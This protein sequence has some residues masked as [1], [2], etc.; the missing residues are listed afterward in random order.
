MRTLTLGLLALV[1]TARVA[2]AQFVTGGT[3]TNPYSGTVWNNPMSSLVATMIQ[4]RINNRMLDISIARSRQARLG[5]RPPAGTPP[6][7]HHEPFSKTAFRPHRSRLVVKAIIAGLAQNEEQ[8][9]GLAAGI[10][11]VFA[12]FEKAP[13]KDNVAYALAFMIAASLGV[14]TGTAVTDEQSEA[15]AVAIND[16]L[17]RSRGFASASALDRQK[18]YEGCVTLGGLVMLFAEVGK[19][20]PAS[21]KAAKAIAR[22]ALAM[23]GI[24]TASGQ[25]QAAA[26]SSSP[27]A[28][29]ASCME[30]LS[31]YGRCQPLTGDCMSSCEQHTTPASAQ[32]ARAVLQCMG[33]S[34]CG[35]MGCV[36]QHCGP[37]VTA[38]TGQTLPG[39]RR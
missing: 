18:L 4:N 25:S 12:E 14:Q 3:W 2:A 36:A 37:Q 10:D 31:C 13:R 19:R 21:A 9:K 17:A 6:D 5:A 11:I 7:E 28:A 32:Q 16:A 29:T 39:A 27:S 22:Q 8:R 26:G 20:D 24:T 33:Q 15:L 30:T 38:C 23:V 34:H 1:V 35:D